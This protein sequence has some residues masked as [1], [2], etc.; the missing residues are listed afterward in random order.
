[1]LTLW[2]EKEVR[3]RWEDLGRVICVGVLGLGFYQIFWSIGLKITSASNSALILSTHLMGEKIF[4]Q[5]IVGG[6]LI[7]RG[8]HRGLRT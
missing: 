4:P 1:M 6:A 5:Q 7:L 3:I 2:R 8:V